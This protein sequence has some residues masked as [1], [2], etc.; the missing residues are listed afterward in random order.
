MLKAAPPAG[1]ERGDFAGIS[2]IGSFTRH[3]FG[4][5]NVAVST[6]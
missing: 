6:I 2:K 3:F 1:D 4:G 5:I